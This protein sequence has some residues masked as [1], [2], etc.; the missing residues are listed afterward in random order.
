MQHKTRPLKD[1]AQRKVTQE[2]QD[3]VSKIDDL[4]IIKHIRNERLLQWLKQTVGNSFVVG[5]Q[6][7]TIYPVLIF[8]Q[9]FKIQGRLPFFSTN[10][11]GITVDHIMGACFI[12]KS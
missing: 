7:I 1:L 12:K 11:V 6:M 2:Q 5:N 9:I 4:G 8:P 3:I 10:H